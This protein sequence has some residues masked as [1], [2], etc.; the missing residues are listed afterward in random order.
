MTDTEIVNF[1]DTLTKRPAGNRTYHPADLH[2]H[3]GR[4]NLYIRFYASEKVIVGE[5]KTVREAV[6]DAA[7]KIMEVSL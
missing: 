2:F 1:F 7:R 3:Q 6:E 4:A 5:G